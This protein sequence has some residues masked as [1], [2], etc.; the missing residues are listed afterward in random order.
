MITLETKM[1]LLNDFWVAYG[2]DVEFADFIE[3]HDI[4]IPLAMLVIQGQAIATEAGVE[5]IE[6]DYDDLC[7]ELGID[8]YGEYEDLDEMMELYEQ[9]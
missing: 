3:M 4:G 6:N 8:K 7:E 5:W 1:T 2:T 9:G